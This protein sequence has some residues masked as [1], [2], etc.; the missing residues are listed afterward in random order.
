MHRSQEDM[1]ADFRTGQGRDH[2]WANDLYNVL[3]T[4]R[5]NVGFSFTHVLSPKTFYD[6]RL[7]R[8]STDYNVPQ[9]RERDL[10]TIVNQIGP[11]QLNEAPF[12]WYIRNE[13][14]ETGLGV[15]GHWGEARDQSKVDVWTTRFDI[16][17]QLNQVAQMKAG[18]EYIKSEYDINHQRREPFFTNNSAPKF[19]WSRTPNQAAA[20]LQTKLEFKAM[21]ANL[22]VRLDHWDANGDWFAYDN[23]DLAFGAKVGKDNLDEA[24]EQVPIET[25][26]YLSPRLGVSFPITA[27]SKLFFNY[28]HFRQ[29]Q[30]P[31]RT[32]NLREII[33]GA[34]DQV[35]NPGHPMYRNINYE[36]GFEQNLF[37]AFLLRMSGYYKANDNQPFAVTYTNLDGSSRYDLY[38]PLNYDDIRG[39]EITLRK[40]VG[41]WLRGFVNYTFMQTK[42]GN[43]GF[44]EQFENRST[45]LE[46]IRT[47][48]DHYQE[49]PV[50]RPFGSFA[51]TL[52]SPDDFGPET[53]GIRPLANWNVTMLGNWLTGQTITW[54]GQSEITGLSNN[55]QWKDFWNLDLRLTKYF[56]RSS[57]FLEVANVLNL[58]RLASR[59]NGRPVAADPEDSDL[60]YEAYMESLHLP[61][62]TFAD[63]DP[64]YAFVPGDDRPGDYRDDGVAFVPIEIVD[65]DA[66]LPADGLPGGAD[67]LEPDRR[68]L[69]YVQDSGNYME[70]RDG[71]WGQAD[72]GFVDQVLDDKAYIDMPNLH[73][74][75][76]LNPRRIRI[77]LRL[78][79]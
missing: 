4:K 58:K 55:V 57:V 42:G 78:A 16:T 62:D 63:F 40:N 49:K 35:G 21:I 2:I 8:L 6:L 79:F 44:A 53:S 47:S 29:L 45:Q 77:G 27:D 50:S 25:Q 9:N 75:R 51:L 11:L 38:E 14:F 5:N 12:G 61:A 72:Q 56:G 54:S 7:Q 19:I 71:T 52:T 23:Y 76:F 41:R 17:S 59:S 37:D 60:D 36:L 24:L 15:G 33:T 34:V 64:P 48:R 70:Y 3:T 10:E 39:F 66:G 18:V 28:G 65:S 68:L 20:Y 22:G 1:A 43:F 74:T 46:F 31:R 73:F 32:F 13:F 67:F 69:W 30:D 26:T